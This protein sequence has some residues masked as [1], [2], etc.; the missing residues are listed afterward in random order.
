MT[1]SSQ[2][3][4]RVERP[5]LHRLLPTVRRAGIEIA[6]IGFLYVFYCVTRTF[7]S[8]DFAPA[9]GR[10]LDLL[11]FEKSWRI[12]IESGLNDLFMKHEWIG[13]A[14]SYWYATT[15]YLV[16]LGVLVWLYRRGA[17]YVTARRALVLASL[18]GLVFYLLM[19]TAPPRL[20]QGG[21]HD[22]LS[23]NSDIGWWSQNG[24]AP[25]GLGNITNE[26]AAFPS[27]H[28]GWSLWVALVLIMAGVPK[29]VQGLGLAYALT[30]TIVIVGT[31]NHWL[32][33]A[34]AGWLV[35]L[36]AYGAVLAWER[37]SPGGVH[38]DHPVTP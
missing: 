26:L 16:T 25:K 10:A 24:S 38:D 2:E 17:Q 37:K 35:V 12:D 36:V 9:R 27:L 22:V 18:I 1:Q 8:T 34:I 30:M 20:V 23:L 32:V 19:P 6:L 5:R 7:A 11:T 33:D 15:H 21:Y 13:V 3:A 4:T 14:S 29:I 31:G 28:A